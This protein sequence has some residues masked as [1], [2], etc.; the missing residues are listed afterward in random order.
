[1]FKYSREISSKG[2]FNSLSEQD[3][4][5][6][7]KFK[8]YILMTGSQIGTE[9]A[10]REILRFIFMVEKPIQKICLDDLRFFLK[11]LKTSGFGDLTKNKIRVGIKRFL[12]WQF[13]DWSER[14]NELEDIKINSDAQR[15]KPI[16][17]KQLFTEKE[18]KQLLDKE[19][20]LYWKTFLMVQYEA[21][22]RTGETRK[23]LWPMVDF[24]DDGFTTLNISSSKNRNGTAKTKPVV[25]KI[26]GNFLNELKNQQQKY[27]IKTLYVF[28]SPENPNQPISKSGTNKWFKNL[29]KN[30][31]G[32]VGNNY[33]LRHTRGT[34]LQKK[35]RDGS[36]SKDN[37]VEF[38]RHSE[39]MFDLVY[40]HMDTEDIKQLI[41]KQIYNTKELTKGE[42][43]EIKELKEKI[44]L[45]EAREEQTAQGLV[46]LGNLV[47]RIEEKQTGKKI[48]RIKLIENNKILFPI[49]K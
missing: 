48:G 37:A 28:P 15:K 4:G 10:E 7:N 46:N 29:C 30:V 39:K 9:E 38:M 24:G 25:V 43:D 20:S 3:K 45:L 49:Q 22:L 40:S 8:D 35:V 33:L 42:K 5:I 11:E 6:I 31:L 18:I 23:L 47:I 26:A 19:L 27:E 32:R 34:E 14:F 2:L 17:S 41:K 36:L 21:G 16:T 1:M 12:R 44:K 13:K